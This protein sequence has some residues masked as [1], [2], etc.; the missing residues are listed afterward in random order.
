MDVLRLFYIG[1]LGQ[2]V[3]QAIAAGVR[4]GAC[5]AGVLAA[6]FEG[7]RQT[8]A[9]TVAGLCLLGALG[10]RGQG[11]TNLFLWWNPSA[12]AVSYHLY[13]G[14]AS[15]TYTTE[16]PAGNMTNATVSGLRPGSTY[17]FAATAVD[18]VGLESA[19]S[20]E[21]IY[22]VPGLAPTIS[23]ISNQVVDENRT[24]GP[25]PFTVTDAQFP[26][27]SLVVS[28]T[29]ANLALVPVS[30]IL[31]G[32]SGTNRTVTVT[33]ALGQ[34]GS[35]LITLGVSDGIASNRTSFILTVTPPPSITLTSPQAGSGF[36]AP[37]AI[38]LAAS[39]V[40][41]GH[42][43]SAVQFYSGATLLGQVSAPPYTL[44]WP[45]VSAGNYSLSASVTDE[46]GSTVTSAPVLIAVTNAPAAGGPPV[47]TLTSP[48]NGGTYPSPATLSLAA[49]VISNGHT[50][51]YVE[52][53]NGATYLGLVAQPPYNFTWTETTPGTCT[54][55]AQVMYD[56]NANLVSRAS[57]V[58]V[59][60]P[61]VGGGSPP[62]I[63][64]TSPQAGSGFLA[65]AAITLTA[66]VVTNGH[67]L[68]AVQFYSGA[69][70]LGQVSAPPYTLAWTGVSAGNYSLS[71]SV[72][73]EL[74]SIVTSTP[75]LI[76]VT[77]APAAGG[78]PV[79]TLTSPVNG[80]TYPSPATLSLAAN[81]ISNGHTINYVEFYNGATYLG[82]VAQPPYNFTWTETT[83]GT[84][85]LMAQVMYDGNAN[86]VSPASIVQVTAPGVGGGS[87]P[88]ITLTSPQAGS[89]FLAPATIT[90]AASVVT[91]GHTLSAVQFYSGTT[92]LGQVSAPPYTLAW[93]GVSAGNYSLSASVSDELGSTVTLTPVLI[94]V[95]NAPA[96]GGP[97]VLTLTSPV[98]GGTYPSPATLSLAANVISNG[99]T[100][101]YVE[102][103]NGATYL[104]LV[105]QPPYNFTWT[106]T[107]PGTCTLM[108][109]VMYDGNAN[110]VSPAITV[111]VIGLLSPWLNTDI[112][113]PEAPGAAGQTN[114]LYLIAGAGMIGG[115][116]DSCQ[117]VYQPTTGDI[118]LYA[119]VSPAQDTNSGGWAGLM[120]RQ[121]LASGAE[122]AAVGLTPNGEVVW[123]SR[124]ATGGLA[125]SGSSINGASPGAW[126][127]LTLV[128]N[129]LNGF[130]SADGSNWTSVGAI[131]SNMGSSTCAGLAV[132][133]G[134]PNLLNTFG[135]T[136]VSLSP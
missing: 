74:G 1:R 67:T 24:A 133:S 125:V 43:V 23:S 10:A 101:N 3:L 123:S 60:A 120:I 7:W 76:A 62:S 82:L 54:L 79:L 31:L 119:Y 114:G 38:T 108:A 37:A 88:S 84:C 132:S 30:A 77:N 51:D 47:I 87:P 14:T 97:P 26:A 48:V 44:A 58:Q 113:S 49:N 27:S 131:S 89:G 83:P 35:S 64:L 8:R 2:P 45:G 110:L 109:Q 134:S 34:V 28:A 12:T 129:T 122:Y 135:F 25:V 98:N 118:S 52:F 111:E 41:N 136:S 70:L 11:T 16:Q 103:Y 112:G 55:M 6:F 106:E 69:T 107:T 99:H 116:S 17:Y 104:G 29:S 71:A 40:T 91:N 66:S 22:S 95:T 57:I 50:I 81:V 115:S 102:F 59:T 124:A 32:G 130:Y 39:V 92:L 56:G 33:P 53:Y 126:L 4:C 96:A 46:L 15:R 127:H 105:A 117:F 94:A 80:G 9:L 5:C 36:L 100:I 78:P 75:V 128:S 90:L 65:P 86:L 121:S 63:T 21:F 93:T 72:T 13:Y 61:G 18:A 73:D 19:F 42:T 68:S 85:T 20:N